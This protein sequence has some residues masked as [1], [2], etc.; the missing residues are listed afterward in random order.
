MVFLDCRD[1]S[2]NKLQENSSYSNKVQI[3]KI[4]KNFKKIPQEFVKKSLKIL[5]TRNKVE[6]LHNGPSALLVLKSG[7][8]K[9]QETKNLGN[10]M[11]GKL[12]I[13]ETQ[14]LKFRE[15]QNPGSSKTRKPKIR[16]AIIWS[17]DGLMEG[18]VE[19]TLLPL[20]LIIM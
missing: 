19:T 14:K 8:L 10:P 15:A 5:I 7:K 16:E 4:L 18:E 12:K 11:S 9:I 20:L 1:Y 13:R 3:S 2:S 6:N 17:E